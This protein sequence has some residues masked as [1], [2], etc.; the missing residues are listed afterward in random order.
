MQNP[1]STPHCRNHKTKKRSFSTIFSH[2]VAEISFGPLVIE[3]AKQE[4]DGSYE[5]YQDFIYTLLL[6]WA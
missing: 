2:Y 5:H 4:I 3:V 6:K 1:S